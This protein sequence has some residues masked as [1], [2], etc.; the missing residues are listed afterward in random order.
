MRVPHS[1]VSPEIS[2]SRSISLR[3]LRP[4]NLSAISLSLSPVSPL[5][6]TS[7]SLFQS[8]LSLRPHLPPI[9][10]SLFVNHQ[11]T[12]T[13]TIH[14]ATTIIAIT[15]ISPLCIP[16]IPH[17]KPT[18]KHSNL[19]VSLMFFLP[20]PLDSI[21]SISLISISLNLSS[22]SQSLSSLP[23]TLS[24]PSYHRFQTKPT[25][26]FTSLPLSPSIPISLNQSP[27]S[28]LDSLATPTTRT[29]QLTR[30]KQ[31]IL[32]V[33]TPRTEHTKS[34]GN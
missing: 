6:S 28:S 12:N 32:P 8:F 25:P 18:R 19:S 34:K 30:D 20:Q 29:Q 10:H 24:C 33:S 3:S 2:L 14:R 5:F 7:T 1:R 13:I 9:A 23:P 11:S 21:L 4:L 27:L 22:L 26:I 17:T 15:S 31:L 16:L